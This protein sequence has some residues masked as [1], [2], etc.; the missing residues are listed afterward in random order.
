MTFRCL[1]K[2]GLRAQTNTCNDLRTEKNK[3]FER[4]F[5][6]NISQTVDKLFYHFFPSLIQFMNLLVY[7]KNTFVSLYSHFGLKD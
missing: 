3:T 4:F 6:V 5:H 1:S 7:F 2:L